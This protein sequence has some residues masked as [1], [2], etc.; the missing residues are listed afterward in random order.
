[1]S[2]DQIAEVP[3]AIQA[4]ASLL[5]SWRRWTA[6]VATF[7]LG[8]R[9]RRFRDPR[10][11]TTLRN[12]LLATLRA[13]AAEIDG[14]ERDFY[15]TLEEVISPWV[16]LRSLARQDREI[17]G[18]LLARCRQIERILKHRSKGATSGAMV[19][20]VSFVLAVAAALLCWGLVFN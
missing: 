2:A 6:T 7:A 3:V 9:S 8:R 12:Q 5:K 19:A 17:L 11:F 20:T 14:P 1:R 18:D 15:L 16:H 10:A 4:P 13:R